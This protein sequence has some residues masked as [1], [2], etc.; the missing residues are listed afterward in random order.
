MRLLADCATTCCPC[1][2]VSILRELRKVYRGTV[3]TEAVTEGIQRYSQYTEKVTEGT[4]SQYTEGV[5]EGILR[6]L[7]KKYG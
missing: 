1:V 7:W 2:S 6:E 4:Q 3:Y 5:T